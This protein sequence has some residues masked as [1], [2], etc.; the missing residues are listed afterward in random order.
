MELLKLWQLMEIY[1]LNL[2]DSLI[3]Y[4]TFIFNIT[5]IKNLLEE[6][7]LFNL[8]LGSQSCSSFLIIL[9]LSFIQRIFKLREWLSIFLF[10]LGQEH[11]SSSSRKRPPSCRLGAL[12]SLNL[13]NY[14]ILL[15]LNIGLGSE[16]LCIILNIHCWVKILPLGQYFRDGEIWCLIWNETWSQKYCIFTI[17]MIIIVYFFRHI[18]FFNYQNLLAWILFRESFLFESTQ[19]RGLRYS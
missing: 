12:T 13:Q 4:E 19:Q 3:T 17:M 1:G 18:R 9:I 16:L 7:D 6:I 2:G 5:F 10:T 14:W 8:F 11:L 15:P